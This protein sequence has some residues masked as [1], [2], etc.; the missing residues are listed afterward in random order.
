MARE[1]PSP[2]PTLQLLS[3]SLRNLDV[4]MV[5]NR[6]F[7]WEN[8]GKIMEKP[9]NVYGNQWKI[10]GQ[11]MENPWKNLGNKLLQISRGRSQNG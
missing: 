11:S 5:E 3:A 6:G 8:H 1:S 4:S 7:Q 10:N 2:G 9:W